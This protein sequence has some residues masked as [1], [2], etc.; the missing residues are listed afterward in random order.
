[1][2]KFDLYV[3]T[4][5]ALGHIQPTAAKTFGFISVMIGDYILGEAKQ[6]TETL[7]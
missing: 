7:F 2:A 4:E 5:F 1:L 3:G 6:I